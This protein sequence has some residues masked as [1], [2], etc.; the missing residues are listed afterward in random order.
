MISNIYGGNHDTIKW[1]KAGLSPTYIY[2]YN[3]PLAA[4]CKSYA[5]V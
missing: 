3:Q 5:E 1:K 4:N 2:M